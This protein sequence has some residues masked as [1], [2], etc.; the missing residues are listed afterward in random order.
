MARLLIKASERSFYFTGRTG[1]E[2]F[3]WLS[4]IHPQSSQVPAIKLAFRAFSDG[5]KFFLTMSLVMWDN[6]LFLKFGV[7]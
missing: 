1:G 5:K 2:I 4:T 3:L 7:K 6:W